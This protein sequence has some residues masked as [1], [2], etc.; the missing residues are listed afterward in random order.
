MIYSS[1]KLLLTFVCVISATFLGSSNSFAQNTDSKQPPLKVFLLVGQSNMQGHAH[2]RTFKHLEMDK[3][4]SKTLSLIQ[5][6]AGAPRVHQNVWI[7]YLSS[8]GVK[9]GLLSTGFGAS[10]EKIGP[11][12]TFGVSMQRHLGEPILLIKTAWGGKSI[13]TDFRPPSAGA[14]QFNQSQKDQFEK[15]GKDFAEIKKNRDEATGHYYRLMIE[16]IRSTLDGLDETIPGYNKEV[17][18]ELAGFVWFQGW[19]DMVD[20]STYPNRDQSGGYDQYSEVLGHFIR[21]VRKDLSSPKLPFV[22]GVMGAGGPVDKYLPGQKRYAKIHQNF[23]DAMAAPASMAE[24][25]GNVGAALTENCWDNELTLLRDKESKIRQRLNELKK[26]GELDASAMKSKRE[27]LYAETFTDLERAK[28]ENG[29]SNAEFHYLGSAKVMT[30]IG[31][32]FAEE[33]IRLMK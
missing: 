9:A 5:D 6:Q 17:G 12:L 11:E 27:E 2:V 21:D 1:P 7:S 15:Q 16:H 8:G 10:D 18:Y 13:N 4:S 20:R 25:K 22:V 24:F 3:E 31:D 30:R 29:V 28:L 19:N 23:R 14:Y 26:A 33:L 32:L